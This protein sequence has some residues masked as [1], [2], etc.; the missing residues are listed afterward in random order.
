MTELSKPW[1]KNSRSGSLAGRRPRLPRPRLPWRR[2]R[3]AKPEDTG[4]A[5]RMIKRLSV[6]ARPHWVTLA[7]SFVMLFGLTAAEL[8]RPWPLKIALDT[9][10]DEPALQGS[11][12]YWLIGTVALVIGAAF[13]EGLFTFAQVY[14][15]NRAGKTI[16]FDI[17]AALFDHI[18][19]LSL[20]YHSRRRSG[21]LM[22]R[23]TGDVKTIRDVLTSSLVEVTASVVLLLSMAGVLFWLDWQLA[24]V[25][26][27]GT[28]VGYVLLLRY[29]SRIKHI[30][31]A[32]RRSEGNL[33][34]VLHETLGSIRLTRIFGGEEAARDKFRFEANASLESGVAA[35]L[36]SERFSWVM[37]V[38]GSLITAAVFAFGVQRVISGALT[39]GELV[40]FVTYIR[41]YF[42]P[43][44]KAVQHAN[45]ISRAVPSAE[46]VVELLDVETGV[47][48]LPGA[49][50]A[51]RLQGRIEFRGVSFGYE[52]DQTVLRDIDLTIPVGQITAVVG[53]T[54]GGKSTLLSLIPRLY[55]PGR[56]AVLIDGRN[57]QQYTLASLR[58]QISMVLQESV[59]FQA[60]VGDNIA[61]GNVAA[62]F[63]EI[64]AA[65]KAANAH[66][67]ITALPEG[68][69][70]VLGERGDTLSGGQRQ[71]IAIARAMIRNAPIL[72][73]DEPLSGLDAEAATAV[74]EAL[75]RL[76]AGKTVIM[77]THVLTTV[78]RADRVVVL[79]HGRVV[80]EGPTA[81]L[82]T[83]EGRL[84]DL[85]DAQ[86][87]IG[88]RTPAVA[89]GGRDES[90]SGPLDLASLK[91]R[92]QKARWRAGRMY[93]QSNDE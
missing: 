45:K 80:Q 17:R 39:P 47:S 15:V 67:F 88:E 72:I 26:L 20:Q 76:I 61:Y 91:R 79:E 12:L 19:E 11:A 77:V 24:L 33:A 8:L 60:S 38:L 59:L 83:A 9:I 42:R 52:T 92:A 30:A 27:A 23:V 57:V 85:L 64:V 18:Q 70:T 55:D 32:E 93:W 44:K 21:D 43:M 84:R 65:A 2:R 41:N 29:S 62:S 51:P 7:L 50:A 66:D 89:N 78:Q 1:R 69:D 13:M 49:V 40:I 90:S 73:L 75:E 3:P 16:V 28:P 53:P 36:T 71:R 5:W 25:A 35:Q 37:E 86:L 31:R 63:E 81:E 82:M 22:T 4:T 58:A 54:G 56:G 10:I 48:D 14:F 34:S 46:R 68:Y 87:L 6:F 74:M